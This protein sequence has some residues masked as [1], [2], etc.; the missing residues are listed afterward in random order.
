MRGRHRRRLGGPL[1]AG[2]ALAWGFTASPALARP[3]ALL[4]EIQTHFHATRKWFGMV[5]DLALD[6]AADGSLT[7]RFETLH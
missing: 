4:S 1:L 2:W 6:R 5:S 7:P 3:D